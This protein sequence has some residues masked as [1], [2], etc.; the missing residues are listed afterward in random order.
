MTKRAKQTAPEPL[1]TIAVLSDTHL[2]APSEWFATLYERYLAGA[3]LVLHCGDVTGWQTLHFLDAH[4][5][6]RAVAGNMD[7]HL[8]L[9]GLPGKLE[10][11]FGGLRIGVTHGWGG[12]RELSKQVAAAFPG[13]D[14]VCFGHTHVYER[15]QYGATTALNPGS[16]CAPRGGGGPSI[17]LVKIGH[18]GRFEIERIDLPRVW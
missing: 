17:A 3:D 8:H 2:D 18:E 7:T 15:A 14:L 9:A 12:G 5:R 10:L 1:L 13:F 16:C 4:P 6:F 11:E